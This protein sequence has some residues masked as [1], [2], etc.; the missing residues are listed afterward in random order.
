MANRSKKVVLSA[1]IEP[2]LK[3]ALDIAAMKLEDK[4]VKVLEDFVADGLKR[5]TVDG[6]LQR[7]FSE[8]SLLIILS[9]SYGISE[10][11][12]FKNSFPNTLNLNL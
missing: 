6:G 8:K 1:R 4:V 11:T 2:R 5:I 10:I 12:L 7:V 3:A 9:T